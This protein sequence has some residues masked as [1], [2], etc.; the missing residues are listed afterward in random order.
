MHRKKTL[1][2]QND[3]F[4]VSKDLTVSLWIDYQTYYGES[5][6]GEVCGGDFVI[7]IEGL[8]DEFNKFKSKLS[9]YLF[10]TP[11]AWYVQCS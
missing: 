8:H 3:E 1:H 4:A 7:I 9:S 5:P 11:D 6:I 2:L 10:S